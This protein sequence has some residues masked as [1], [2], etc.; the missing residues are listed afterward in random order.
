[1]KNDP[2]DPLSPEARPSEAVL[3]PLSDAEKTLLIVD[4]D[5]PFLTRVT[6]AME[7][8]GFVVSM[9]SSV[10]EGLA[11]IAKSPPASPSS[12]CGLPTAM[13]ST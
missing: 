7:T 1:M 6:R 12:T 4:D 13:G 8:R 10:A 2:G 9:A 5:K 11:A 3:P